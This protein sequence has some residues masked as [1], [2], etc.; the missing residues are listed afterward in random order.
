MRQVSASLP[1]IVP[2]VLCAVALAFVATALPE[3]SD[4]APDKNAKPSIKV[5]ASPIVAFAPA[6]VVLTAEVK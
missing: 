1:R 3:A 6:R 2:A 4:T 5:K